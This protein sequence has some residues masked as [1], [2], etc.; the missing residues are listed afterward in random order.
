MKLR[1]V[2]VILAAILMAAH[3]LRSFSLVPMAICLLAPFLLLIRKRWSLI[4]LQVLTIPA[5]LIWLTTLYGIIQERV[6]EGRSWTAS[7]VILGVVALFT[8]FAGWLL[9][10]PRIKERY[11][12]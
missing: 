7:A 6:F 10:A 4:T 1:Y 2:P 9:N 12:D 5:A 11:L 8:L 3:F